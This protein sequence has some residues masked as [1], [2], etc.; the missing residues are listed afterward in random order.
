MKIKS[1]AFVKDEGTDVDKY[2]IYVRTEY[3]TSGG[4]VRFSNRIIAD[5]VCREI[6]DG[7]R[8]EKRLL[9]EEA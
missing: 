8:F 4:N 9:G 6:N 1:E 2:F 5:R 3:G 7:Y